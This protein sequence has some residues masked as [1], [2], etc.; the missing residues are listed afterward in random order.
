MEIMVQG[1]KC[2]KCEHVWLRKESIPTHCAKCH[3]RSWNGGATRGNS[4][5]DAPSG[6]KKASY[7]GSDIR[8]S[9]GA[10][11]SSES[12]SA[13]S[14]PYQVVSR[15]HGYESKRVD[16]DSKTCRVYRCGLC[17][18]MKAVKLSNS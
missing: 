12:D 2:D 11:G 17:A 7:R 18:S 15:L 10:G 8:S 16:H 3:T 6:V 5:P 13:T 14:G 9:I 4:E 1:W